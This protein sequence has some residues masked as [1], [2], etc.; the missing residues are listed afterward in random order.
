[1]RAEEGMGRAGGKGGLCPTEA[2]QQAAR[3]REGMENGNSFKKFSNY[4]RQ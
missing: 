3:E 4:L 2:G 1:M